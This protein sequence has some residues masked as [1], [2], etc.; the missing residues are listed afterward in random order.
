MFHANAPRLLAIG[1]VLAFSIFAAACDGPF[2]VF[3]GGAISGEAAPAPARWSPD[4]DYGTCQLET[5]G[6]GPYSVNIA[7]TIDGGVLYVNA[8]DTETQWV[9]NMTA[10]PDVRI[11]IDGKIYALRAERVDD[12]EEIRRFGRAW[13]AQSMFRRDPGELEQVR[14]YRLVAR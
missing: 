6:D 13:T 9:K 14:L 2:V 5:R 11:R 4:G 7:Y 12:A 3:P 8:G 1:V 10:D